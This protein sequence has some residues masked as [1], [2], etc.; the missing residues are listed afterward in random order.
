MVPRIGWRML[1][2][3]ALSWTPIPAWWTALSNN[4][5]LLEVPSRGLEG[6]QRE[7]RSGLSVELLGPFVG[8]QEQGTKG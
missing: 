5:S 6:Q 1:S 4:V 8:T 2:I 7:R 3:S